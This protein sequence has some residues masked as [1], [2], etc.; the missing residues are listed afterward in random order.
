MKL[1][2]QIPCYNEEETLE[3]TL[4][5]LPTHIEGIDE[6]EVLII[7]DGST[8]RTIEIAKEN[9]IQHIINFKENRGLA[10]AFSEGIDRSIE[11]GADIIVNTDGD[12]QYCGADIPKLVRP[13]LN[14]SADIVIGNRNTNRIKHFSWIKRRLQSIGTKVVNA[15]SGTKVGD[16][17]CG[18]RAYTR[19]AA[20]KINIQTEFSYTI[21]T[22]IQMG[23]EKLKVVSVPVRTNKTVRKSRL[24][25]NVPSFIM[26]QL[27]TMIRAYTTYKALTLFTIIAIIMF[28]PGF[29]G[30]V[31]FLYFFIIGEGYGHLQS[32]VV[33]V[34]LVIMS[35][36]LFLV[37]LLADAVSFNRKLLEKI[38]LNFKKFRIESEEEVKKQG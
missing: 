29:V 19:E 5:E 35:V 33:S 31:R 20:M 26:N 36:N 34:M 28:I 6:I 24:A 38:L 15:I 10:A 27:K 8:D 30:L 37:G 2:I 23:H 9:R 12:N 18:F 1:I 14:N 13:I 22:L 21:E 4:K 3:Q 7:D 11:L 25:K 16:S 17:V 32:L